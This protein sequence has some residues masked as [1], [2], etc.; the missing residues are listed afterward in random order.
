MQS[1]QRD[2]E[3]AGYQSSPAGRG[4]GAQ[5]VEDVEPVTDQVD[6]RLPGDQRIA[7]KD[8]VRKVTLANQVP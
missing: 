7:T 2:E 1:A 3:E 8:G 6:Q 5:E 4:L